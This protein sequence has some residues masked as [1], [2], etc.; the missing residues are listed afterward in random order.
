MI[1]TPQNVQQESNEYDIDMMMSE[2]NIQPKTSQLGIQ[3]NNFK[4]AVGVQISNVNSSNFNRMDLSELEYSADI[5]SGGTAY[6]Q[7]QLSPI[8]KDSLQNSKQNERF[9]SEVNARNSQNQSNL[10]ISAHNNSVSEQQSQNHMQQSE[11]TIVNFQNQSSKGGCSI[12]QP[13][14]D[15]SKLSTQP[16]AIFD[17]KNIEILNSKFDPILFQGELLKLK[18]GVKYEFIPRW[19]QITGKALRYYKNRWTQ[20]NSLQKPLSAIPIRA[21]HSIKI[22]ETD[23]TRIHTSCEKKC[24]FNFEIILKP[25]FLE[26]YLDPYYDII[27][28]KDKDK[29]VISTLK[30]K[31][32]LSQ[33][34]DQDIDYFSD[35]IRKQVLMR[36]YINDSQSGQINL[37][38]THLGYGLNQTYEDETIG[39]LNST[40][41]GESKAMQQLMHHQRMSSIPLQDLSHNNNQTLMYSKILNKL[42]SN[43]SSPDKRNNLNNLTFTSNGKRQGKTLMSEREENWFLMD[44]RLIFATDNESVFKEWTSSL[45]ELIKIMKQEEVQQ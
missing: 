33:F 41:I 20:N 30:K 8:S 43:T 13:I 2:L 7:Q 32:D 45:N 3:A 15:E 24:Q 12:Q 1:K 27:P 44:K 25:D 4:P 38:Q 31:K 5:L 36:N 40:I 9:I 17:Y 16:I 28:S 22:L 34:Q 19:I 14:L 37:N 42:G 6:T 11:R 29:L 21:I 23:I 39:Q 26:Q 35:P 10:R 18:P